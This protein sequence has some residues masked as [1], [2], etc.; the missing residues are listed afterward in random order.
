MREFYLDKRVWTQFAL[1][2]FLEGYYEKDA[3]AAPLRSLSGRDILRNVLQ[4]AVQNGTQLVQRL[5][6]YIFIG[7]QAADGLAVDVAFFPQHI[8]GNSLFF[9][10][11]PK[12]VKNNHIATPLIAFIMGVIIF[13]NKGI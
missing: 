1:R 12:S 6:F 9:H 11:Y 5:G 3:S 4:L 2:L 7:F 10:G 13:F 8:G